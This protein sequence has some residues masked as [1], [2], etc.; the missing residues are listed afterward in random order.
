MEHHSIIKEI[1]NCNNKCFIDR[2]DDYKYKNTQYSRSF[3]CNIKPLA[4]C[5]H[6]PKILLISQNPSLQAWING[7]M[8]IS[9]PDGGL[10]SQNNNFLTNDLLPAF[11]LDRQRIELFKR[12]VGWVHLSNCYTWFA[13]DSNNKRKDKIPIKQE[14]N[15]CIGQ[16]LN[17]LLQIDSIQLVVPMGDLALSIFLYIR[18]VGI[19]YTELMKS[20][21]FSDNGLIP[22]K[23]FLPIFHQ[24]KRN[25]IFNDPECREANRRTTTALAIIFR[26]LAMED[27]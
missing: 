26:E 5:P 13:L 19:S 1:R 25:R 16:W 9:E 20:V 23:M 15:N 24:S 6:N 3:F 7:G 12:T 11:G 10:I 22:G 21:P 27:N 8:H 2:Y 17:Q 14:I 18:K 4:S